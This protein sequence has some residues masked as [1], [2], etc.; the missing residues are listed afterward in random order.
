MVRSGAS[1]GKAAGVDETNPNYRRIAIRQHSAPSKPDAQARLSLDGFLACASGFL[2]RLEQSALTPMTK[3]RFVG[4]LLDGH[5]GK[6]HPPGG[7]EPDKFGRGIDAPRAQDQKPGEPVAWQTAAHASS[8]ST[9]T[10]RA[11]SI[12]ISTSSPRTASTVTMNSFP[13]TMASFLPS[14]TVDMGVC[15]L[16]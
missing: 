1:R 6:R 8:L 7:R 15:L 4:T 13:M 16:D 5:L 10:P 2:S 12:P 14:M 9:G 11:R 3:P